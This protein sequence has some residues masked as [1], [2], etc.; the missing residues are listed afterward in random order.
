M[1]KVPKLCKQKGASDDRAY[2]RFYGEKFYCG[3]WGSP[4]AQVEY[5]HLINIWTGAMT[6]LPPDDDDWD[7]WNNPKN[8][9]WQ[10]TILDHVKKNRKQ[11]VPQSIVPPKTEVPLDNL[12]TALKQ[13]LPVATQQP[14]V[15]SNSEV[16]EVK[17]LITIDSLIPPFLEWAEGYYV[18][19]GRRTETYNQLE[20]NSTRLKN[21]Y[22]KLPV[23]KFTPV[24]LEKLRKELIESKKEPLSREYVNKCISQIKQIF[25]WGVSRQM[26][27]PDTYASLVALGDLK[28]GRSKAKELPD[29]PPVPDEVINATLPYLPSTVADMVRLQR[30]TGM[31]P[32]DVTNMRLC[33]IDTSQD[34]WVYVP[35]EFKTEHHENSDRKINLGPKCQKILNAY[36][37]KCKDSPDQL[38]L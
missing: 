23:D 19:N 27:K 17:V 38:V 25:K 18:K 11:Q 30:L 31:R 9:N 21:R 37:A 6:M 24:L 8:P 14:Q 7:V 26:V 33:D 5:L 35:W 4:E 22:G 10:K 3:T 1:Q 34:V 16:T 15:L 29:V 20:R 36:V 28:K 2:V 32:Q 12:V 13:I